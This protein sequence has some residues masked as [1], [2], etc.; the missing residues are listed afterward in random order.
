MK[1]LTRVTMYSFTGCTLHKGTWLRGKS[2]L[3]PW[4]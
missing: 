1:V 3:T 4:M 2:R